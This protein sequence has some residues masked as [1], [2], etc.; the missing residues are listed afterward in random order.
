MEDIN[1]KAKMSQ[2]VKE[3]IIWH[4]LMFAA[5]C[6]ILMLSMDNAV[7][8]GH[9]VFVYCYIILIIIWALL[10]I[11][12]ARSSIDRHRI[13]FILLDADAVLPDKREGDAG[14]DIYATFDEGWM[15]IGPHKTEMVPTKIASAFSDDYVAV[16]K[17]RGS[18]GSRGIGQRAGII[19]SSYR[20]EW[21]VPITNHNNYEIAIVKDDWMDEFSVQND[22]DSMEIIPY[23]KAICQVLFL[24]VPQLDIERITQEEY[25]TQYNTERGE[26]CLGSSGKQVVNG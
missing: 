25:V 22:A 24:P 20:G 8:E 4:I 21:F 2:T 14:Y 16:L 12:H 3:I 19:D 15:I 23:D 1:G 13:K 5:V 11:S 18:I 9:I 10:F 26:G 17:E 7:N 6:V